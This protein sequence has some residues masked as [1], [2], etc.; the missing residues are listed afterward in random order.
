M[1]SS[2]TLPRKAR[3]AREGKPRKG[4]APVPE[5]KQKKKETTME[6]IASTASVLV[7]GL[8]IVTFCL[9]AFEIPS[10]SMVPALLIGDHLFVDRVRLAPKTNWM[11][12]LPYHDVQRGDIVV[13]ISPAEPGLFLVKRIIGLPGDR[14]H[15]Q[16]GAVYRN[17]Q[18]LDEH[19]YVIHSV[20]NYDPFRDNFPKIAPM[21]GAD[22]FVDWRYSIRDHVQ[23][24]DIVVPK[25]SY[26]A[27]GDNRDVSRDSRYWG[28]VPREN[29][30]G[31]P[32]FIYWSF[33]TPA[34]QVTKT[35]MSD[36]I[37]FLF[38]EI[39]HFFTETR[40]RRMLHLVR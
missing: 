34:D 31:R 29:V 6:F 19:A 21:D 9:Q 18:K 39:T 3:E 12:L 32:M 13:F 36:R 16:D 10:S 25:N 14:I 26:F 11:P 22:V 1:K 23:G 37:G 2:A 4:E 27:M 40:W 38:H 5:K 20:G 28:F 8:F 24:N 33:E 15:L 7:V 17:G 30:V 35:D